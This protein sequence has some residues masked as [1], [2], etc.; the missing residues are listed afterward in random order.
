MASRSK[1]SIF[2]RFWASIAGL[3]VLVLFAPAL[4]NLAIVKWE[5]AR[6]PVPGAFYEVDGAQMH[7]NCT[8]AGSPTVVL[9]H[10]ATA[11]YMLWRRV[12]PEL[13]EVTRACFY[14][15]AG[16]PLGRIT[17]YTD[18][19][20]AVRWYSGGLYCILCSRMTPHSLQ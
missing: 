13:S 14:E 15:R 5:H 12:Q 20:F 17:D 16:H 11:S 1:P 18:K 4:V 9:E 2:A 3:C 10:A 6:N 7:I 19:S 8:G